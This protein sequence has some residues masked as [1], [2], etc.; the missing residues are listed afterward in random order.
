[1]VWMEF[2]E[3]L[4][5]NKYGIADDLPRDTFQ[6][7]VSQVEEIGDPNLLDELYESC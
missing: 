6:H 2:E 5:K 3:Y 4:L 7:I 1:M